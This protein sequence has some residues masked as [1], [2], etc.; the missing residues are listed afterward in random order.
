MKRRIL[1]WSLPVLILSLGA[2]FIRIKMNVPPDQE[3]NRARKLITEAEL[4]KS[5]RYAN[6][7]YLE[8]VAYYDSAMAAW[9]MENERFILFRDYARVDELARTSQQ[10]S[11]YAI[12][13]ARQNVSE[14]ESDLEIRLEEL[15]KRISEFD[16]KF[17]SFPVDGK[18]QEQ[19]VR[20]K[21]E[22]SEGVLAYRNQ[23][24]SV[25]ISLFNGVENTLNQVFDPYIEL[26]RGYLTEYPKWKEMV[27]QSIVHSK[28]TRS[29]V[30]I[31]DKLARELLVYKDGDVKKRYSAELG[32]NWVGDKQQQGDKTTPEGSYTVISKKSNGQTRYYKALML[33]YP[34]EEDRKRFADNK[35]KGLINPEAAIG[36]LIEIHGNGGKGVDW[37]DGC[38]ALKDA[39]MD[40][41]F[42]WCPVG[43]RVT[44]VGST[45][46]L[47]ELSIH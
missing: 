4:A 23:D 20:C 10:L 26:F 36:G 32:V 44:I 5:P 42:R 30:I 21:L 7:S 13:H 19:M 28:R 31:V 40:V 11:T 47:H 2:G 39:D 9:D 34:N 41:V 18:H 17:G 12:N 24:Y 8:A 45:K 14:I 25:C 29:Y 35:E 38:I 33:D 46:S 27:Q 6:S 37:T 43:T 16:E 15:G 3:V 22:Y 1:L